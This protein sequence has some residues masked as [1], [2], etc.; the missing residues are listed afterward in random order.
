M[1]IVWLQDLKDLEEVLS[2]DREIFACLRAEEEKPTSKGK[3]ECPRGET[4]LGTWL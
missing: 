3:L 4:P 1:A 2:S